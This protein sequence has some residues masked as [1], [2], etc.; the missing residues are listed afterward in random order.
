MK[1]WLS[2]DP[3]SK[4]LPNPPV[5]PVGEVSAS[6]TGPLGAV[7]LA[8]AAGLVAVALSISVPVALHFRR[9]VRSLDQARMSSMSRTR[10]LR[11]ALERGQTRNAALTQFRREVNRYVAD[12]E[13]RPLIPW[14]TFVGELS[15]RRPKGVWTTRISGNGPHF[16][17]QVAAER[18]ELVTQYTQ[19]LRQS[20]YV[21]FAALP[22]GTTAA[23]QAQ[24]VGRLR[25]E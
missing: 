8:V 15:R 2:R 5:E 11:T 25:G 22:A 4:P 24:V 20:P 17:A 6:E 14:T 3:Q 1:R 18:P 12:V 9:E 13:S 19:S 7:D 10:Q 23:S 16:R 21:D